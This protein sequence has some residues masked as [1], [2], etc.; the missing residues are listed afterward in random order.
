M[1][2]ITSVWKHR[3]LNSTHLSAWSAALCS[4]GGTAGGTASELSGKYSRE[5][6]PASSHNSVKSFIYILFIWDTLT[7][8]EQTKIK[9]VKKKLNS[10]QY[11]QKKIIE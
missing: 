10:S 5:T 9:F 8:H 6:R 1:Y 7:I 11:A 3:S 2:Y 4:K